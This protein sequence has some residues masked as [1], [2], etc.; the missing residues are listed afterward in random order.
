MRQH[1]IFLH[2]LLPAVCFAPAAIGCSFHALEVQLD[3]MYPG[4]FPV[5]VALRNAADKGVIDSAALAASGTGT[6]NY[7][8]TVHFL[9]S[10]GKVL[11]VSPAAGEL[12]ANFSLG[13]VDSQLWARYSQSDGKIRVD[14]HTD[15]PA[16]G[17]PV[18]LTG[19]VVLVQ[20]L[21][22]KLTVDRALADGMLL[23][24][25]SER[26]QAVIRHALKTTSIANN[27]SRR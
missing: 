18:V 19:E 5:A 20:V 26:D 9:Q 2:F 7:I 21:A 8:Y 3:R 27:V 10:F 14:I 17:E 12:P 13:Y 22:G 15:G 23:I 24:D 1:P 25:G 11:A 16:A 6:T 4:S